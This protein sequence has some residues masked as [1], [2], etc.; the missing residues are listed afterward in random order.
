MIDVLY[1]DR[2]LVFVNKLAGIAVGQDSSRDQTLLDLVRSWYRLEVNPQGKGYCVPIHFLDRPVSGVIVFALSSKAA[3]RLNVMFKQRTLQKS[4]VT[5]VHGHLVKNSGV[6][7]NRLVKDSRTNHTM[8]AKANDTSGKD[9]TLTYSVLHSWWD[10]PSSTVASLLIVRPQTGRSHQIRV[11]LSHLGHPIF[12][13]L[14]YGAKFGLGSRIALHAA[15]LKLLH[16]VGRFSMQ[17]DAPLPE[18]WLDLWPWLRNFPL[19]SELGKL[20]PG[21]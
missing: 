8:V 1:S 4:Y 9:S 6:L 17:I 13:D 16:P 7:V 18:E 15:R 21:E 10:H 20:L 11:Q 5:I 3:S 14:R 19:K 2:H 12:G